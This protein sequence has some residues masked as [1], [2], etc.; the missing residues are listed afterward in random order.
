MYKKTRPNYLQPVRDCKFFPWKSMIF[1]YIKS[2]VNYVLPMNS[3]IHCG[4]WTHDHFCKP[5]ALWSNSSWPRFLNSRKGMWWALTRSSS[6][7][8]FNSK[9][10]LFYLII[11]CW[12]LYSLSENTEAKQKGRFFPLPSVN[13]LA[14]YWS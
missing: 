14:I 3:Q 8:D 2:Y 1:V 13:I 11:S 5:L 7:M 4:T 9:S 10:I 6:T 12:R